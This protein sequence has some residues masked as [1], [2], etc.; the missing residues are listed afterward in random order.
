MEVFVDVNG[1]SAPNII[2]LDAFGGYISGGNNANLR[3]YSPNVND[4][5]TLVNYENVSSVVKYASGCLSK[6]I[7]N[8][9]TIE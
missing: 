9:W 7:K 5:G 6:V 3:D 4:C 8:G 1:P 2:G